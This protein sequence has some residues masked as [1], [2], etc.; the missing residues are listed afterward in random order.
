MRFKFGSIPSSPDF[1][2]DATWNQL[3]QA[4][5]P[6][7][8]NL[9]A[10][11][12]G[13]AAAVAVASLGFLLTPLRDIV[14]PMS[15]PVF[16]LLFVGFVIVHELIHALLHPMAG[17]SQNSILGFWAALGF[18]AHYD[19]EMSRNRLVACLLM[20]LL[21]LSIVPL[22]ASAL[23]QVTSVWVAFVSALNA[24]CASVDLLLAGSLLLQVPAAATVRFKGW[25][26][27]WRECEPRA[28]PKRLRIL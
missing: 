13:V 5:A 16:L 24:F 27:S 9:L 11:P 20:P 6:W 15:L 1:L 23:T 21:V 26:I 2:P 28:T 10:L 12:L 19:G 8:E 14:P 17:F 3:R 4:Q 25:R 7:K 22:I 18:Y